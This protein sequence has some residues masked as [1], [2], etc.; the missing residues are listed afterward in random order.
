M[1]PNIA[2][3]MKNVS[4]SFKIEVHSEEKDIFGKNKVKKVVNKVF[5][6]FNLCIKKGEILG[7]IGRNGSGKSTLLSLAAKILEPDEGQVNTS[8]PVVSILQLGMGFQED[9]SGRENIYLKAQM[10]GMSKK[11]VDKIIDNIILYAGIQDYVDNPIRTYSTGMIS[12]LAFS[13]MVHM[14]VKILIADEV[15]STGD[16]LFSAK[17]ED[18]FKKFLNDGKTV[19]FVSH[20][21]KS[22][23]SICTRVIWIEK[24]K[25]VEDG[26]PKTICSKYIRSMSE[27]FEVVY[28]NA[29]A[30]VP[31]SQYYLSHMYRDGDP[32]P[33][34]H[35]SYLKWLSRAAEGGHTVAQVEYANYLVINEPDR[36]DEALTLFKIAANKGNANARTQLASLMGC[37][38]N[39]PHITELKNILTPFPSR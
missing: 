12:R 7:I 35:E 14:N 33:K 9:M 29:E 18:S 3:E 10:Y 13:V 38:N 16:A 39:N 11:N 2:I 8:G 6:N 37:S 32:V 31:E 17:A 20:N 36:I 21:L 22:V 5:D 4:K 28:D 24:G 23:E 1:E 27:S 15:L 30:G 25:I 19:L 26:H 34:N